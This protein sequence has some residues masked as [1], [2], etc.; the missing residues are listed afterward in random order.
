MLITDGIWWTP[1][2][3]TF[4]MLVGTQGAHLTHIHDCDPYVTCHQIVFGESGGQLAG[5]FEGE[6]LNDWPGWVVDKWLEQDGIQTQQQMSSIMNAYNAV[7][8]TSCTLAL[9]VRRQS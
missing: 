7:A 9:L 1:D 2:I 3:R 6:M 8:N 4:I 5:G